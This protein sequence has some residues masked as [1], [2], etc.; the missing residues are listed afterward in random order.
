[1]KN[2]DSTVI[3]SLSELISY[4]KKTNIDNKKY[5]FRGEAK[6]YD[7]RNSSA[8]RRGR[9]LNPYSIRI[10]LS[11]FYREVGSQV[12][13]SELE[14]FLVYSQHHGIATN[15]LD[16]SESILIAAYFASEFS[17]N[18][19]SEGYIYCYDSSNC[20]Y[21]PSNIKPEDYLMIFNNLYN[22]DESSIRLLL[23]MF[24]DYFLN[25]EVF[26]NFYYGQ[27][28]SLEEIGVM[29][30]DDVSL[31]E[32]FTMELRQFEKAKNEYDDYEVRQVGQ[33][34]ENI[35]VSS[36]FLLSDK[37]IST[38]INDY[39]YSNYVKL[40]KALSQ[41]MQLRGLYID[42]TNILI[43]LLLIFVLHMD[44]GAYTVSPISKLPTIIF[45]TGIKFDRIRNQSGL[46]VF[47][48]NHQEYR[49]TASDIY[50]YHPQEISESEVIVLKNKKDIR[51]ELDAIGINE[52]FIYAN[53]DSIANYIMNRF[54]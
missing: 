21:M 6:K 32:S 39:K 43:S 44:N 42:P 18:S 46:F 31:F 50:V 37:I 5:Y 11:E 38:L 40:I 41:K 1:M 35:L 9:S 27:V 14:N 3:S 52:K 28:K 15:L 8:Y 13:H 29:R 2:E 24:N 22:K 7:E 12:N 54:I 49:G 36:L 51:E 48:N 26:V 23:E 45:K 16:I 19:S 4:L 47:Q 25:L 34:I 30:N 53:P 20:L 33:E 17:T 10:I